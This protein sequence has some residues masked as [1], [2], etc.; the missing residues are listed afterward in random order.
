MSEKARV[1][2]DLISKGNAAPIATKVPWEK[3]IPVT[4]RLTEE[5]YKK[6]QELS[7]MTVPR[8]THQNVLVEALE[9]LHANKSEEGNQRTG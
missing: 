4:V 6:L 7:T 1:G 3:K 8:T 2:A 9:S 5:Q